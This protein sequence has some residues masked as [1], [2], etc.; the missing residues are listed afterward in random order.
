MRC[1]ERSAVTVDE[2]RRSDPL[3]VVYA[4]PPARGR[5]TGEP[6]QPISSITALI[7][8]ALPLR[9]NPAVHAPRRTADAPG[10][11]SG[12][13]ATNKA[14]RIEVENVNVPGHVR[15]VDSEMY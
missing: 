7:T 10:L 1:S 6:G 3:G 4:F 14:G 8:L 15:Y 12:G 9:V 13:M 11:H 5:I 2:R